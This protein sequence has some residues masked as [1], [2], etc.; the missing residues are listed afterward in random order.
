[1]AAWR[2]AAV[3]R[4]AL[5][6]QRSMRQCDVAKTRAVCATNKGRAVDGTARQIAA[7]Y[8]AVSCRLFPFQQVRHEAFWFLR[9]G[10][11]NLYVLAM[12]QNG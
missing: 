11:R 10:H 5:I 9:S 7:L 3:R 1:M 2:W 4:L 12:G 6:R 8:A